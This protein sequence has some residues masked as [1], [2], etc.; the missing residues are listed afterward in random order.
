V[1]VPGSRSLTY[2][3]PKWM[4]FAANRGELLKTVSQLRRRLG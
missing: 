2:K 3:L 1:S 4:Q